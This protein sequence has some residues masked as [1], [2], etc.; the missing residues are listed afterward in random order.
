MPLYW[1]KVQCPSC[2]KM[3]VKLLIKFRGEGYALERHFIPKHLPVS[4][5]ECEM[6]GRDPRCPGCDFLPTVDATGRIQE[7]W[8][9]HRKDPKTG[10]DLGGG[11]CSGSGHQLCRH[12][13]KTQG[14]ASATGGQ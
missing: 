8:V 3:G 6:S 4:R 7:H 5:I 13:Q 10:A 12:V 9:S 11:T 2:H 14:D 1:K